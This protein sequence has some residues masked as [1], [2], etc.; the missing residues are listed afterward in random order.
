MNFQ[1]V[2]QYLMTCTY[3]AINSKLEQF[4]TTN[5]AKIESY[6]LFEILFFQHV[7]ISQISSCPKGQ[8][9]SITIDMGK[10]QNL[11]YDANTSRQG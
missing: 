2:I 9:L 1:T 6:Q 3:I 10:L 4:T 11:R 5:Y 7:K 8:L